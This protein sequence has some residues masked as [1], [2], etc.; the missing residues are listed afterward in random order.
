MA[1][2]DDV[3]LKITSSSLVASKQCNFP[4]IAELILYMK[5]CS[6]SEVVVVLA[7]V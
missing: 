7:R 4:Y 3:N 6:V 1:N 5:L 2:E